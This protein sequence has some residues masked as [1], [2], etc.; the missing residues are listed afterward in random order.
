MVQ[1]I[2]F[3]TDGWR[4]VVAEDYTLDNI[5]DSSATCYMVISI[6]LPSGSKMT[7]S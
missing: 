6:R 1:R 7:L 4:G 2:I 5:L 3:G